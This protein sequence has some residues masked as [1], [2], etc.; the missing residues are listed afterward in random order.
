MTDSR[1]V[2]GAE[3]VHPDHLEVEVKFLADDLAMLRASLEG[4]GAEQTHARVYERN[5]R[6]DTADGE[7]LARAQLLRL[8]QDSRVRLTFKAETAAVQSEAKVREEIEVTLNNFD[9][10]SLILQRLGFVPVQ[11]YEKYRETYQLGAVEV[12]LDELPFGRFVELEGDE[13]AIRQAAH[14]LGFDWSR[15]ILVNYLAMMAIFKHAYTL[16]FDDI[17]FENFAGH[18]VAAEL[19]YTHG[20]GGEA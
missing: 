6:F 18:P 4:L 14:T 16:P 3:P 1:D 5:V 20:E 17:T 12:V 13:A 11:V 8:R 10:M 9:D 15:R 2:T 19:L 7:L